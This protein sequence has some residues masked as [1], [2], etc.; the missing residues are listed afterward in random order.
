[1][2]DA[3][4]LV[5]EKIQP[6]KDTENTNKVVALVRDEKRSVWISRPVFLVAFCGINSADCCQMA[7]SVSIAS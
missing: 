4:Q 3:R 1:M 5:L 2:K 7:N 6:Q